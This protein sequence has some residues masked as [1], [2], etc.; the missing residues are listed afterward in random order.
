V[1]LFIG[2]AFVS[3]G[4]KRLTSR[5]GARWAV[6]GIDDPAA[7]PVIMALFSVYLFVVTPVTNTITR[8]MEMEADLYGLNA[9][10]Q[11]DGFASTAMKLS[12]Y[13]KIDP[14]SWEE[15]IFYD[16]PSGRTR[17]H[18]AMQWKAEHL[19]SGEGMRR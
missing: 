18:T 6:G 8:S 4:F 2:F 1:V 9:A 10:G 11:P 17:V 7:F 19:D 12:S 14:G 5:Y 16:H 15:I 3:W 13:R